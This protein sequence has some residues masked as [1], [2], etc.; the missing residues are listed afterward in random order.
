MADDGSL[1]LGGERFATPVEMVMADS[2]KSKPKVPHFGGLEVV[3]CSKP[4]PVKIIPSDDIKEDAKVHLTNE[5]FDSI[6]G[7]FKKGH[8]TTINRGAVI[9]LYVPRKKEGQYRKRMTFP[10]RVDR[11]DKSKT[12]GGDF[13][14]NGKGY[15]TT[16]RVKSDSIDAF[17]QYMNED[18]IV[19]VSLKKKK[20]S[21]M[22]GAG[23]KSVVEEINLGWKFAYISA[24]ISVPLTLLSM[25]GEAYKVPEKLRTG[26]EWVIGAGGGIIH[27]MIS[28]LG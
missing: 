15:T 14:N 13:V 7:R 19:Y 27:W 5:C 18:N 4:F 10:V 25:L 22:S 11:K 23:G 1:N 8:S 28:Q 21:I 20:I 9:S 24:L 3:D 16:L 6:F 26:V 2:S 12:G 17:K